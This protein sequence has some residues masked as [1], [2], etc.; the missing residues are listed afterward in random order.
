MIFFTI[1]YWRSI[2]KLKT[3][4]IIKRSWPLETHKINDCNVSNHKIYKTLLCFRHM[5]TWWKPGAG[6]PSPS[7]TKTTRVSS[8][9][10]NC[11]RPT[12]LMSF[13]SRFDNLAKA[14][15]IGITNPLNRCKF[16]SKPIGTIFQEKSSYFDIK[17]IKI[18]NK[19]QT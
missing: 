3:T 15:I 12:D 5:S 14:R 13:L 18:L 8:G 2:I 9:C 6:S 1:V 11:S 10:R 16:L 7:Y 19:N 4:L 17:W